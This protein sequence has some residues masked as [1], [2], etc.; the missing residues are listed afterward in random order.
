MIQH[1]L[2]STPLDALK[3][4]MGLRFLVRTVHAAA[5]VLGYWRYPSVKAAGDFEQ[6]SLMDKMYWAYKSR[7]PIIKAQK[8]SN[9][10]R[11]FQENSRS[12]ENGGGIPVGFMEEQALDFTGVG[13]LI[14]V[15]G[16][17]FSRDYLYEEIAGMVFSNGIS[18]ANLESQ[19]TR[20]AFGGYTFNSQETPLLCLSRE[21]YD[22]LKGH[23]EQRFTV[24]NTACNHTFDAGVEG[25]ETTLEQLN[26]DNILD[27][28]TNREPIRRGKG[29]I[30]EKNHIKVGFISATFG[31]SGKPVPEGKEYMVNVVRF[32]RRGHDYFSPD[33]ALLQEQIDDCRQQHC[34]V[35]IAS[36]HWGYEYEFFP[37]PQQVAVAHQLVEWGV[38]V[39]IGHHSHVLQP[40]EFYRPERLHGQSALIA[41]SLGNLTSSFSA[42][43][44]VLSG[45]LKF[46]IAKGTINGEKKTLVRDVQVIPVVQQETVDRDTPKLRLVTLAK[47]HEQW[48]KSG[49]LRVR[50]YLKTLDNY[51]AMVL[52]RSTDRGPVIGDTVEH[53]GRSAR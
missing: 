20:Q 11:F 35:I 24:M 26:A 18:Y 27:L 15:D 23:R 31:L 6:M 39:I 52:G 29:R 21:Q 8:G 19:L 14:K 32:H 3:I 4:S 44:M 46:T 22:A 34:D 2:P 51:V 45:I 47:M 17:E 1:R 50:D 12:W 42:P 48:G 5:D 16:L 37:R 43:H 53:N 40:I 36:L 49:E 41:Y 10:E 9:L 13:D 38:D 25:I 30:V 28:G 7:Q 33:L